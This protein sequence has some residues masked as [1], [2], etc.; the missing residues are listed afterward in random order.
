MIFA[1]IFSLIVI[2]GIGG[3]VVS[4]VASPN[5]RNWIKLDRQLRQDASLARY[6]AKM[7]PYLWQA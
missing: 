4:S 6:P 2:L 3:S 5:R 7:R 1:A